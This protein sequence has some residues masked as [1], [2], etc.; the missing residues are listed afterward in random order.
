MYIICSDLVTLQKGWS[1]GMDFS[2]A[3]E[4]SAEYE[5]EFKAN[6][7]IIPFLVLVPNLIVA[8]VA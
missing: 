4:L 6:R 5:I 7:S 2:E 3:N 1:I 8:I